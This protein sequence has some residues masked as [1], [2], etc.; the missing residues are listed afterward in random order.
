MSP[1]EKKR[2]TLPRTI[3]TIYFHSHWLFIFV[4]DL[5]LALFLLFM[6]IGRQNNNEPWKG[7]SCVADRMRK[8]DLMSLKI[9]Y[10]KHRFNWKSTRVKRNS[11]HIKF[12]SISV[13]NSAC[14]RW[15]LLLR[16]RCRERENHSL[17]VPAAI[18]AYQTGHNTLTHSSSISYKQL[19]KI[20]HENIMDY[21]HIF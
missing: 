7:T 15:M 12:S 11:Q 6:N 13:N 20:S 2:K 8:S 19:I 3:H 17:S 16:G 4:F 9:N 1:Q 10:I 5:A 21:V 18:N 14:V